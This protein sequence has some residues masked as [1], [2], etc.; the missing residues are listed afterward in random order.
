MNRQ[1]F[2]R[3]RKHLSEINNESLIIN[4]MKII[5]NQYQAMNLELKN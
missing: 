4:K 2:R 1:K 5:P 3:N